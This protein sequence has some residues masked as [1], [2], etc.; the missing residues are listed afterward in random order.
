M[1]ERPIATG[2][3]F[4]PR[5]KRRAAP[6]PPPTRFMELAPKSDRR[7]E[8][9]PLVQ[10][11]GSCQASVVRSGRSV[12]RRA[13]GYLSGTSP[14]TEGRRS[15]LAPSD[16]QHRETPA[17]P[18]AGALALFLATLIGPGTRTPSYSSKGRGIVWKLVGQATG[19]RLIGHCVGIP[20]SV[21]MGLRRKGGLIGR[22]ERETQGAPAGTIS[23]DRHQDLP[24][25]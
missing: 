1:R 16:T 6:S 20:A 11:E 2:L 25:L 18:P 21:G 9:E 12:S 13:G 24:D 7:A 4:T 19:L 17:N 22:H 14:G 15:R 3:P 10:P 8:S 23:S 5:T